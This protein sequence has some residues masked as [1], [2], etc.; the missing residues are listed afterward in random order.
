[1]SIGNVIRLS[2]GGTIDAP[3]IAADDPV[4]GLLFRLA[5]DSYPQMLVHEDGSWPGLNVSFFQHPLREQLQRALHEDEQLSRLYPSEADLGRSGVVFK[6]LGGGGTIQSVLFGETLVRASWDLATMS[7]PS[8][9]LSD[10]Y[11]A[12][13]ANVDVLRAALAGNASRTRALL[14]VTGITTSGRSVMTPWGV[15]R[16]ISEGERLA[17]PATLDGAVSGTDAEGRNVTVSYAGEL[18]LDGDLPYALTV[19]EWKV[20]DEF[21]TSPP[22]AQMAGASAL[23]RR[24]EGLQLAVLLAVVRPAGQWA[25]ARFA[26]HWIADPIAHGRSMSWADHRSSPG[27]MPTE[28]SDEECAALRHWCE[29]IEEHWSPTVDIAVRRVLSASQQRTNPSDRL[30]D[31]VIAWENLFGTS[32]GEPRLRISTAMA[33]LLADSGTARVELQKEIKQLYDDRSKIVH[34]GSFEEVAIAERANRALDLALSSLRTL[35]GARTDILALPDGAARSLKLILE[36]TRG[37][38]GGELIE[39]AASTSP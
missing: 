2:A 5:A 11:N 32:E 8:P 12:I 24:T 4:K 21:P 3:E 14:A 16:P 34:G 36:G 39:A 10:L 35:F 20:G 1:M 30:V 17:A 33:W 25:T 37:P 26:W 31:S 22:L 15:L 27:L 13:S 9:S 7:I 18:V 28:V 23:R 29:R 19:R 6:S 38:Q